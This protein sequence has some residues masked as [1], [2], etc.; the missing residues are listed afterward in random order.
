M[1]GASSSI[2]RI[3]RQP[4]RE[5][6]AAELGTLRVK[7]PFRGSTE[8]SDVPSVST[9]LLTILERYAAERSAAQAAMI[10][11]LI[12]PAAAAVG[13]LAMIAATIARRRQ[14]AVPWSGPGAPPI[15]RSS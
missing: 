6:I 3:G 5:A 14:S 8:G 9:G 1:P 10:L 15:G 4:R 2:G 12:G 13:A 11:A 7:Y